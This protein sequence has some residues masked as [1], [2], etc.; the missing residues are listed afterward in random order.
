MYVNDG[1]PRLKYY[2][3]MSHRWPYLAVVSCLL[4]ALGCKKPAV[5]APVV[6]HLF[7]DLYSPYAHEL[8]HRI[9]EFQAS[10]PRLPS[11]AP[12]VVQTFDSIEYKVALAGNFERDVRP[13][14]VILNSA[15]DAA[16]NPFVS[17]N[18]AHAVDI[19]AA[20]KACP[21]NVPAFVSSTATGNSAA[22]AQI[23]LQA[24]AQHK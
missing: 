12:I 19:C 6:V 18:M 7:R 8:D 13:E 14:A 10:N 24:L 17:A 11:G 4:L 15:A 21:T 2:C 20:V 5:H 22:A 9:L 1:C 16:Q 3:G 23:F